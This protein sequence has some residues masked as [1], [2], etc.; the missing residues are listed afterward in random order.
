GGGGGYNFPTPDPSGNPAGLSPDAVH[1]VLASQSLTTCYQPIVHHSANRVFAHE[2]LSRPRHPT[3]GSLFPPDEWFFA[4][5]RHG[6]ALDA[7]LLAMRSALLSEPQ[8]GQNVERRLFINVLPTTLLSTRF[9][10]ELEHL[11]SLTAHPAHEVVLEI[12]ESIA[13]DPVRLAKQIRPLRRMGVKIAV[14]DV[15]AGRTEVNTLVALD[16]DFLKVDRSLVRGLARSR[17]RQRLLASFVRFMESGRAVIAEG[18]EEREDLVAL[19][20]AGVEL[21]QGF[22]WSPPLACEQIQALIAHI[23]RERRR[24]EQVANAATQLTDAEVLEQ[25]RR[26]DDLI[27]LYQRAMMA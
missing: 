7:D 24:L 21:S 8:L 17:T 2:A 16:P 27:V 14:D 19:A 10:S 25:S 4:A 12:T 22:Y 26:L 5:H 3:D 20:E 15:G 11:L 1:A 23:E 9:V 13:F 18:V 6:R